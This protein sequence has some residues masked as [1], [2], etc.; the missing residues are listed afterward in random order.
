VSKK[1]RPKLKTMDEISAAEAQRLCD[2]TMD[3]GEYP[4]DIAARPFLEFLKP[5]T[6]MRSAGV[7]NRPLLS[8]NDAMPSVSERNPEVEELCRPRGIFEDSKTLTERDLDELFYRAPQQR[9]I[10]DVI[11]RNNNR[12][13]SLDEIAIELGGVN[14]STK[15]VQNLL[16]KIFRKTKSKNLIELAHKLPL[17]P[18]RSLPS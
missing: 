13:M 7:I 5:Y 8:G 1:R 17:L 3:R 14:Q 9:K 16:T 2:A 15:T 18:P 12:E 11:R 4:K 10:V 6:E